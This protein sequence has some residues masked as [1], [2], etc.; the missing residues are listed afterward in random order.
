MR[1]APQG[2][3]P[4]HRQWPMARGP[5][6]QIRDG[7]GNDLA[8]GQGD[9]TALK[10]HFASGRRLQ[11]NQRP[12]ECGFPRSVGADETNHLARGQPK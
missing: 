9:V 8:I 6:G 11:T 3:H 7:P 12:Q 5:A 4:A 1:Q 2:N 10:N